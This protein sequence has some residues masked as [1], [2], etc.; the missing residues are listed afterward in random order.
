MIYYEWVCKHPIEWIDIQKN[1]LR[2]MMEVCD[3]RWKYVL[4]GDK[5]DFKN[6]TEVSIM[7]GKLGYK[8]FLY[9][10]RVYFRDEISMRHYKTDIYEDDLI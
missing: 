5:G 6:C 9:A 1:C 8:F 4:N 7:A 10:G 2:I 3:M